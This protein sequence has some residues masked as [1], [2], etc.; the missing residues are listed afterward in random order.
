MN[1]RTTKLMKWWSCREMS[2]L[3]CSVWFEMW[4]E[5]LQADAANSHWTFHVL[6]SHS[7]DSLNSPG[8]PFFY[9]PVALCLVM[10]MRSKVHA[11]DQVNQML[12]SALVRLDQWGCWWIE[13]RRSVIS[14][15]HIKTK[16]L[17]PGLCGKLG[18]TGSCHCCPLTLSSAL[19]HFS[20][21]LLS[22][23]VWVTW[24]CCSL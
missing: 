16:S 5:A 17:T 13:T 24:C 7:C 4:R 18:T 23:G 22:Y 10:G 19:T 12:W 3:G 2:E 11:E 21:S 1:R 6:S 8:K 15:D 14:V 9:P 20:V